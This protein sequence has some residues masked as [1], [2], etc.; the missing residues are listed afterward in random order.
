MQIESYQNFLFVY[1]RAFLAYNYYIL[2]Y[3]TC[4]MIYLLLILFI[5]I[6][7]RFVIFA[8]Q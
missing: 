8:A 4:Y 7:C 1:V 3:R 2:L 5:L 6:F